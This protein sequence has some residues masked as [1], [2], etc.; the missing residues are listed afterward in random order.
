MNTLIITA[1]L[2]VSTLFHVD[3]STVRTHVKQQ[4]ESS[5]S[6]HKLNLPLEVNQKGLVRVS[7]KVDQNGK[8]Q[9]IEANYSHEELKELLINELALISLDKSATDEVFFYEFH[10][11]KV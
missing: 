7:L 6:A 10:F 11:E 4:I 9:I 1:A 3:A 2:A 8:L 5:L